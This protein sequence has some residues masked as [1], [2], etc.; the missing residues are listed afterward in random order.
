MVM[1]NPS[2]VRL[3]NGQ[4]LLVRMPVAGGEASGLVVRTP[5]DGTLSAKSTPDDNRGRLLE[6]KAL[7]AILSVLDAYTKIPTDEIKVRDLKVKDKSTPK[8]GCAS[9][10]R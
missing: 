2:T 6:S 1:M 9:R 4:D 10:A 3:P 8:R 7:D 5:T